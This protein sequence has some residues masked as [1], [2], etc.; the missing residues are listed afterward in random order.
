MYVDAIS[1]MIGN[2]FSEQLY[3]LDDGKPHHVTGSIAIE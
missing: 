1:D 3:L 2:D